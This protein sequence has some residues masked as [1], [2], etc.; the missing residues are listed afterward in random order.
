MT[1]TPTNGIINATNTSEAK[2]RCTENSRCK[3]FLPV[4][5]E[6]NQFLQCAGEAEIH[7]SEAG[8]IL[9]IEG[10]IVQF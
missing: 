3:M 10:K 9:Y 4:S 2:Q 7:P 5:G 6:T 1:C 8:S